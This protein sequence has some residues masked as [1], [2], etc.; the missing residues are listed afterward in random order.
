MVKSEIYRRGATL[1]PADRNSQKAMGNELRICDH[2][3]YRAKHILR[4]HR[5][6]E[7][8]AATDIQLIGGAQSFAHPH[9]W[10]G[11]VIRGRYQEPSLT[12]RPS[13]KN[14]PD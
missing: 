5:N 10:G 4:R 2:M 14:F 9:R 1:S 6:E 13:S 8:L 11:M 12:N 3:W 7:Q